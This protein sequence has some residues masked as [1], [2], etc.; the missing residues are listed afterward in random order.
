MIKSNAKIF[1]QLKS[2][3]LCD[4][5]ATAAKLARGILKHNFPGIK[6]SVRS[7]RFAGGSAFRVEWTDGPNDD[8]VSALM[9]PLEGKGF[10][11]SIDMAYYKRT[12]LYSDG[13]F[14]R[15]ST[16]GTEGSGGYAQKYQA[17]ATNREYIECSFG[18]YVST[19]RNI[20]FEQKKAWLEEYCAEHDDELTEA[21][22]AGDVYVKE[23]EFYPGT[24]NLEG[25]SN[26]RVWNDWADTAFY[27]FYREKS[28]FVAPEPKAVKE[29]PKTE[30]VTQEIG[31]GVTISEHTH[32]KKGFQMFIVELADRV[33]RSEFMRLLDRAKQDRG[34]YSRKW[35][36]TP[37][38]FAFRDAEAAQTFAHEVAA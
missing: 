30:S 9:S 19:T 29:A 11:G 23:S 4:D 24:G 34:W 15:E 28:C 38:G 1:Q 37:A 17:E 25:A 16:E 22:A 12:R 7:E 3:E 31:K 32:T 14:E 20:S 36:S 27:R 5:V 18:C 10:D 33:E 2:G 13:T 26:V 21:V 8:E 6:F 35:G